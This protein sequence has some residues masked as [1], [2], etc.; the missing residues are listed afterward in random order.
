MARAQIEQNYK[1]P[2][3]SRIA[4]DFVYRRLLPYPRRIAAAARL[5]G[6][7]QRSGL[8]SSLASPAFSACSGLQERERLLPKID[9]QFF[10]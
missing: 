9:S 2:L 5:L 1:R 10:L 3:V 6:L 4:R 7:Y 8:A